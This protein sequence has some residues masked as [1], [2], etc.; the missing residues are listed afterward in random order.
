MSYQCRDTD[1]DP[2]PTRT[3]D[4]DR[5]QKLVVCSLAY[6]QHSLKNFMQ[7]RWEVFMQSC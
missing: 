7:I 6:C 2:D 5:H 3:R 1:P 4:P